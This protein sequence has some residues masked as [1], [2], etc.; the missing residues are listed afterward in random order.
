MMNSC[1]AETFHKISVYETFYEKEEMAEPH[2]RQ[3]TVLVDIDYENDILF[4]KKHV[5]L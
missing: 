3:E 5:L 2:T 4:D 1:I